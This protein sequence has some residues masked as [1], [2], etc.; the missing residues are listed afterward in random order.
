MNY[1]HISISLLTIVGIIIA[2]WSGIFMVRPSNP[3]AKQTSSLPD[4]Y[5]LDVTATI[6]DMQGNPHM[7]IVTPKMIHYTSNDTSQ[8][9]APQLT[10]YRQSLNPWYITSAFAKA[11]QGIENVDFWNDVTVQHPADEN[12]PNTVI[13]T[14][15]LTV[16]PNKETAETQEFITML[17]PNLTVNAVGM[18]AN[19]HTGDIRLLSQMRGEYAP[20]S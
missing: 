19:M 16:H 18:H 4:A 10:L 2:T 7:K 5:M 13:K 11:T 15:M 6:M 12:N 20:N 1:K 3:I 14:N 9:I 8:L 17:Q